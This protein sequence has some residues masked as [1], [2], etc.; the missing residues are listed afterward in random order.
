VHSIGSLGVHNSKDY[1]S[2]VTVNGAKFSGTTNGVR[3]K[4]WQVMFTNILHFIN[5]IDVHYISFNQDISPIVILINMQGGSGSARN[6]EFLNIEMNNVTNPII[7]DQ[8]YCD[9]DE[10]CEEQVKNFIPQDLNNN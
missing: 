10:P 5:N 1:V 4:T 9:Q 8:N 7:I 2:G 6:I 3:I